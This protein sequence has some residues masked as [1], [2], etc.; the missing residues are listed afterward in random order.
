MQHK[1]GSA[2]AVTVW[3]DMVHEMGEGKSRCGLERR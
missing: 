2:S 1:G 3:L